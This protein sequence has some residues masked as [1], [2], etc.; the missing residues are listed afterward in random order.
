M[1]VTVH[2]NDVDNNALSAMRTKL[3]NDLGRLAANSSGGQDVVYRDLR[4]T[5][6]NNGAVLGQVDN[7]ALTADQYTTDVYS[8]WTRLGPNQ[9]VGIFGFADISAAPKIDEVTMSAGPIVLA[10]LVLDQ[11]YASTTDV[12]GFFFPPIVWVPN[13]HVRIDMLSHTTNSAHVDAFQWLGIV[14]EIESTVAKP[15]RL[16]QGADYGALGAVPGAT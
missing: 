15:R 5:D 1:S 4:P 3:A 11:I 14:A 10:I 12:R 13:E 2:A 6:L 9:A 16:L 8:T 7:P